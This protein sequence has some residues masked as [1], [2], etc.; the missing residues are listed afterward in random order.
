MRA[1]SGK[2]QYVVVSIN[3][4]LLYFFFLEVSSE[5]RSF[6]FLITLTT[7]TSTTVAGLRNPDMLLLSVLF[8]LLQLSVTDSRTHRATRPFV[9]TVTYSMGGGFA[10][11]RNDQKR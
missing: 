10:A 4:K 5:K 1:Q 7:A 9:F 11:A 2:V 3:Y 8:V 6:F